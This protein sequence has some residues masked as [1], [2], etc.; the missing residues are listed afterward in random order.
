MPPHMQQ[1]PVD[2]A[3]VESLLGESPAKRVR[4]KAAPTPLKNGTACS[5]SLELAELEVLLD[6]RRAVPPAPGCPDAWFAACESARG[7]QTRIARDGG[8]ANGETGTSRFLG[9]SPAPPAAALLQPETA[10]TC[11]WM[12]RDLEA[13]FGLA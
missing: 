12:L 9:A 7:A 4:S 6:L 5:L 8:G 10:V 2:L 13:D 11:S 1:C 3:E